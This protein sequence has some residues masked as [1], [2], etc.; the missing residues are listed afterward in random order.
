MK[1]RLLILLMKKK[2]NE[3]LVH[4]VVHDVPLLDL[5]KIKMIVTEKV[6][7]QVQEQSAVQ[8]RPS[9]PLKSLISWQSE[10]IF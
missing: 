2:K 9:Y 8:T 1:V 5:H 6:Q 3:F 4:D 10:G 7:V